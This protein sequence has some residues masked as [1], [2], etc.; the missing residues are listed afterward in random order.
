MLVRVNVRSRSNACP[1]GKRLIALLS[2]LHQS[3]V[4]GLYLLLWLVRKTVRQKKLAGWLLK[5]LGGYALKVRLKLALL[6]LNASRRFLGLY[7]SL[8][9]LVPWRSG[10]KSNPLPR[11]SCRGVGVLL[12]SSNNT[13]CGY[14]SLGRLEMALN[15]FAYA[16][17]RHDKEK[18]NIEV[19][20]DSDYSQM[21]D[22]LMKYHEYEGSKSEYV[23]DFILRIRE[24]MPEILI[25]IASD[26]FVPAHLLSRAHAEIERADF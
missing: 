3:V 10:T 24:V 16:E 4:R 20:L 18:L 2:W 12:K 9:K 8:W 7:V 25:D 23:R 19:L 22:I 13:C 5:L 17:N 15:S 1:I 21:I 6:F 26:V 11:I 14:L